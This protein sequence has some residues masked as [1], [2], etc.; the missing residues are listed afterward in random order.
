MVKWSATASEPRWANRS[1]VLMTTLAV[2]LAEARR[3]QAGY[4]A[5]RTWE[6]DSDGEGSDF[7]GV[8]LQ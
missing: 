6:P 5:S 4:V 7:V 3:E 2:F 8:A 1:K